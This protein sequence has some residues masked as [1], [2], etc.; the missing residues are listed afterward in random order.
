MYLTVMNIWAFLCLFL[1][2]FQ[3]E[4]YV[5]SFCARDVCACMR[6]SC[7]QV[8]VSVRALYVLICV[9][10]IARVC[11]LYALCC[12]VLC[13]VCVCARA[14]VCRVS[15]TTRDGT[16]ESGQRCPH[17]AGGDHVPVSRS[18]P[19]EPGTCGG[20]KGVGGGEG[21]RESER[22]ERERWSASRSTFQH[23]EA[24]VAPNCILR[25]RPDMGAYCVQVRVKRRLPALRL[26]RRI[27]M[28]LRLQARLTLHRLLALARSFGPPPRYARQLR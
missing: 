28:C 14:C 18:S 9:G 19:P 12:V 27:R 8:C 15:G 1:R 13:C 24:G 20:G 26:A 4:S 17:E 21:R 22:R 7:L 23:A 5:K 3:R 6:V 10:S 16:A 11:M 25:R 2:L